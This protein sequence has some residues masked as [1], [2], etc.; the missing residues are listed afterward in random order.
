MTDNT[1]SGETIALMGIYGTDASLVGVLAERNVT[2]GAWRENLD[3]ATIKDIYE[4]VENDA[5]AFLIYFPAKPPSGGLI[6]IQLSQPAFG[7]LTVKVE[8]SFGPYIVAKRYREPASEEP[9]SESAQ[10]IVYIYY[11]L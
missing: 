3:E 4:F 8:K 7:S 10:K 1:D 6:D 2:S 11:L 9:L 5:E